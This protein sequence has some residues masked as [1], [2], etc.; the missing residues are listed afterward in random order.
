M[1]VTNPPLRLFVLALLLVTLFVVAGGTSSHPPETRA[2]TANS[3][4]KP[5]SNDEDADYRALAVGTWQ[6]EYKGKRTMQLLPDGTATMTVELSGLTASLFASRLEFEMVWSVENGRMRKQ[7]LGGRPEGKV[8]AILSMMGDRVDE[9]ILELT[10]ERL[11]LLDADGKTQ[12]DWR[13]VHV[14]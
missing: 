14:K 10:D 1:N 5:Q 3:A 7:T 6:D 2:R 11:L 9:P 4:T 8:K 13:R 12:Y